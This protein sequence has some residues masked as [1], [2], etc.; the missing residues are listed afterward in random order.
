MDVQDRVVG[1]KWVAVVAAFIGLL[2]FA[3]CSPQERAR[4]VYLS[5]ESRLVGGG[6]KIEW[7]APEAG[8]AYLVEKQTGKLVQT[9]TLES[10]Q[11]YEFKVESVV[12][13][14]ELEQ[15]IG[16]DMDKAQFLLYFKPGSQK[17]AMEP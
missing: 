8:T 10:G 15:L 2:A 5:G 4:P 14:D 7:K 1:M 17:V 9:V 11:S 12:D 13:A 3:G 16:I 6:L